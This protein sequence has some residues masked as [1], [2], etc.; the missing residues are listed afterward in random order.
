M[1]SKKNG[2]MLDRMKVII[3]EKLRKVEKERIKG[4]DIEIFIEFKEMHI[5]LVWCL[6]PI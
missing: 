5:E 3:E 2:R 1:K 6:L 4:L